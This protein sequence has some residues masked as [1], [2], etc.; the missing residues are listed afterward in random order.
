MKIGEFLNKIIKSSELELGTL[1]CELNKHREKLSNIKKEL[2][3]EDN[4]KY[5]FEKIMIIIGSIYF[6]TLTF[7][8]GLN[9]FGVI[10]SNF[11]FPYFFLTIGIGYPGYKIVG[12]IIDKKTQENMKELND[13][14]LLYQENYNKCQDKINNLKK[15]NEQANRAKNFFEVHQV[16]TFLENKLPLPESL[17][18]Q[19]LERNIS[20]ISILYLACNGSL[21]NKLPSS[22]K[23]DEFQSI[24][25]LLQEVDRKLN[26]NPMLFLE[27]GLLQQE[28]VMKDNNQGDEKL[29]KET[30]VVTEK[31]GE[32]E[33]ELSLNSPRVRHYRSAKYR[34]L[35]QVNNQEQESMGRNR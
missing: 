32:S 6:L 12:L 27:N 26:N 29:N 7:G 22:M 35:N 9:F 19:Y 1:N 3:V 20:L 4:M 34:E 5:H 25:T 11:F 16:K 18:N 2:I 24:R 10:P 15:I 8:A 23:I 13:E 31:K 30:M 21:P 33:L 28:R 17:I 14:N